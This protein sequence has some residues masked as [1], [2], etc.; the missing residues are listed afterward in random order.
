MIWAQVRLSALCTS[1][2]GEPGSKRR[3]RV[4]T[5][6]VRLLRLHVLQPLHESRLPALLRLRCHCQGRFR[7]REGRCRALHG[8]S[9]V[10]P[11]VPLS[12][13]AFQRGECA[14][15]EVLRVLR[16]RR[17]RPRADLRGGVPPAGLGLRHLRRHRRSS[18]HGCALQMRLLCRIWEKSRRLDGP[19]GAPARTCAL[20]A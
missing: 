4:G 13:P 2:R 18:A 15:R 19:G 14:H 10:R 17:R 1:M 11:V 16:S 9:G 7:V 6:R 5:R 12:R 8:M 3:G 20:C